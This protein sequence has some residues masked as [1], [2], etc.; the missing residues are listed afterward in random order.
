MA[1]VHKAAKGIKRQI[2][3][4][5]A[6]PDAQGQPDIDKMLEEWS[7]GFQ[8]YMHGKSMMLFVENFLALFTPEIR[9][10][11]EHDIKS[12]HGIR[13][14]DRFR[15]KVLINFAV[16]YQNGA[17]TQADGTNVDV[18]GMVK[19]AIAETEKEEGFPEVDDKP[20]S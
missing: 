16:A 20:E 2:N 11:I 8:Q 12:L 9:D 7:T 14:F 1:L 10:S 19:K 3:K 15:R 18:T 6:I 13:S 5:R 4:G 17:T